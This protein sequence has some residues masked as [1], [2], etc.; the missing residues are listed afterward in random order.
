M[1]AALLILVAQ[2]GA[3]AGAERHVLALESAP[4]MRAVYATVESADAAQARARINGVVAA[5]SV[6][7]GDVVEAG[8]RLALIEDP[9]L[10]PLI[11]AARAQVEAAR[12]EAVAARQELQRVR[13]LA[14][15]GDASQARLDEVRARVGAANGALDAAQGELSSLEARRLR[16][17]VTAPVSGRVLE[18]RVT[19]G[20]AVNRGEVIAAIASAPALIRLAL[21]ERHAEQLAELE[22][23]GLE[24]DGTEVSARVV[25]VYPQIEAGRVRVDIQPTRPFE[26]RFTG[27]RLQVSVPVEPGEALIAP[28][29]YVFEQSGL[30]YVNRAEGGRTLVRTGRVWP[31]RVEILAGA[32]AGDVLLAPDEPTE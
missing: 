26:D 8:A 12:A 29:R 6:D 10:M 22:T 24:L 21:P 25:Q 16:G 13:P 5:R 4:V 19:A 1:I 7:E 28:S 9:E 14:A 32:R 2:A 27:R 23:I 17:A 11:E 15:R 31:D 30:S 3:P 20:T 18:A